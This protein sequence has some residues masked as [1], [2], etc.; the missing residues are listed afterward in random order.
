M[1]KLGY[2][3]N[4]NLE[5]EYQ[6]NNMEEYNN[7]FCP[8]CNNRV[9]NNYV[10]PKTI[11][12]ADKVAENILHILY[13]IYF[14]SYLVKGLL[15]LISYLLGLDSLFKIFGIIG[16]IFILIDFING[17]LRGTIGL[18]LSGIIIFICN[19]KLGI[20]DLSIYL[21]I[22]ISLLTYGILK[23]LFIK[24]LFKI[25]EKTKK[26]LQNIYSLIYFSC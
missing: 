6:I 14:Y 8:K 26:N 23:I 17:F 21:G 12:K 13:N 9:S 2:C 4:C 24:L 5:F 15:G 20:L 25:D 11:T 16:A 7:V 22:S 3:P 19:S 1:K 18:L 10:R